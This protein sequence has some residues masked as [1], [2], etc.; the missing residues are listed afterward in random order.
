MSLVSRNCFFFVF[1]NFK[2]KKKRKK[3]RDEIKMMFRKRNKIK[4]SFKIVFFLK[5]MGSNSCAN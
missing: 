5:E 1:K 3:E 2:K 4:F